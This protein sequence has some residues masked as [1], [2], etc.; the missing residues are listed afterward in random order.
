MKEPVNLVEDW[1]AV[2]DKIKAH[3]W[4]R[5]I[6]ENIKPVTDRW[7]A[8]YEDDV[9]RVAGWGHHYF[10]DHCFAGLIFDPEKPS[11]HTCSGCGRP[12]VAQE[13]DD[14]WCYMYRST[15][16]SQVFYAA[17]LHH[18]YGGPTYMAFIRKVL[19]FFS[20]HYGMFNVRTPPGQEGR[21]SGTDLTDGVSVIWLLNGMEL[22]RDE[23]TMDELETYKRR[24][25]LPEA[26]F[27]IEKVGCTP[28]IIC[29][30][31]AA[32][33]MIGLF[34]N[35]R[36]WCELAAE[37]E[38]G[39]KKKLSDGLLPEGFWYEASFHYHFYCAEGMTY[40]LA[41]CKLYGYEFKEMEEALLRMY[42]YPVKYAF[43]NGEFPN[44]NDG[45]PLLKFGSY[46]QQYEWIRNIHDEPAYRYALAQC[47]DREDSGHENTNIGGVARLLFGRNW[48]EERF[49]EELRGSDLPDGKSEVDPDIYFAMLR[50]GDA[51]VFMKY[52]YVLRGHSHA[53]IMNFE[54]FF[55]DE[56]ISRDISNSGYG[57]DLFREW[58]RKTIAHNSV[59][60]DTLNQPNRPTGRI[61]EFDQDRNSILAAADEVYDGIGFS[62]RLQLHEGL[63]KDEF[64][65]IPAPGHVEEHTFDWMFHCSGEPQSD[66]PFTKTDPPGE[67]DGYQLMLE[68]AS[69][70]TDQDW[71]VSW[72][73]ADKRLTLKMEGSPGTTVYLFK[74]YQHR[75]DVMRWGVMVRRRGTAAIY[76]AEYHF[77]SL[78]DTPITE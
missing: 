48:E 32:A 35:E 47:Y 22:V 66:L 40:Y 71:E 70:D 27:L 29:W 21:F 13:V 53:D 46:A 34:F 37:G 4:A 67:E 73:T 14:A 5:Q 76:K 28:N 9:S 3:T 11:E 72:I 43:P 51:A 23:F 69:C 41:F 61:V 6:V 52:G 68:T 78:P 49:P 31:K 60:V 18:L 45:W 38:Y 19:S 15:V 58:Q 65:V 56:V 57:S 39:I 7:V 8:H 1:Q 20:D 10:C 30:M 17:V 62:R 24:F 64:Q 42:R 36:Q 2:K 63:L 33:G 74:G 54:L 16:C 12:R 44:P 50:E 55:K 25:F 77:A 59:M 26:E 75:L